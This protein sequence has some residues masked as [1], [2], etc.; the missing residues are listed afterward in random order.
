[1]NT[2]E[3]K[4]SIKAVASFKQSAQISPDDWDAW[5]NT[6]EVTENT[7]VGEIFKWMQSRDSSVRYPHFQISP[8]HTI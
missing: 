7:T 8:L 6:L 4:T 3:T 1:M 5:T 2:E